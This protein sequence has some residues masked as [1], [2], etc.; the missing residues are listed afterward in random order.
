[1]TRYAPEG[2]TAAYSLQLK[3]ATTVI[4]GGGHLT[5]EAGYGQWPAVRDWCRRDKLAFF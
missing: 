3:I 2:I 5:L 4:P 1:M